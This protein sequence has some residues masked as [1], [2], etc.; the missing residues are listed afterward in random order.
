M[1]F[2]A[3]GVK[4]ACRQTARCHGLIQRVRHGN[5]SDKPASEIN[6]RFLLRFFV[7]NIAPTIFEIAMVMGILFW[8]YGPN[9]ALTTFTAVTVYGL[10]SVR[11]TEWRRQFVREAN[12]ADSSSNI[13]GIDNRVR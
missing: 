4:P 2:G 11:A 8:N 12:E 3:G 1:P 5:F 10:F 9:Y 7:F 13:C 6:W